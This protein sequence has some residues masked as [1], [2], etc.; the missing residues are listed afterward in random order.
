M[1]K[2]TFLFVQKLKD[3]VEL[4]TKKIVK[5][6]SGFKIQDYEELYKNRFP[7]IFSSWLQ[8]KKKLKEYYGN[9]NYKK[10]KKESEYSTILNAFLPIDFYQF[11]FDSGVFS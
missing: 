9:Y 11:L 1:N 3:E 2:E 8:K 5:I 4:K 6:D 7:E 10:D